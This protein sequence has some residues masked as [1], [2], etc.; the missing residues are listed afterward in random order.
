MAF[1]ARD[2][3]V[4]YAWTRGEYGSSAGD[5][6]RLKLVLSG[7]ARVV[8]VPSPTYRSVISRG[9]GVCCYTRT[10]AMAGVDPSE[11]G[12]HIHDCLQSRLPAYL[13]DQHRHRHLL[14]TCQSEPMRSNSVLSS[15]TVSWAIISCCIITCRRQMG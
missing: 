14:L 13:K 9:G 4:A 2:W 1:R 5:K 10:P 3:H 11:E 15:S 12:H 7:D 8:T 6:P